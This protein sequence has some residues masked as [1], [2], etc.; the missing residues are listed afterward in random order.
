[1][2][3]GVRAA[4]C[5]SR[6]TTTSSTGGGGGGGGSQQLYVTS[7]AGLNI[8]S[9]FDCEGGEFEVYW[10]GAVSVSGTIVIGQGT[11]VSIFGDGNSSESSNSSLSS[12]E[13][14][15]ELTSRLEL[16]LGLTS[17]AVGVGSPD[18]TADTDTSVSFGPMFF[19]NGGELILEDLIV[20]GGFA[21]NTTR[22]LE[23]IGGAHGN[24]GG[25]HAINATVSIAR[26]EFV[27]NFAEHWG[28]GIFANQSTLTV[29]DS[30]F[31]NCDAGYLSTIE[32]E[33]LEG[34]G[35]GILVRIL[36]AWQVT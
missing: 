25:V 4:P 1:M 35:G 13:G 27:D 21:A 12:R 33:D 32:D 30:T 11:R 24:G 31:R 7:T 19:V 10:S 23:G 22:A 34:E 15:E 2:G 28:G 8:T 3:T 26:C 17:A 9:A 20:R 18:I 6:T 29:V 16:P 36:D 5:A 14:L